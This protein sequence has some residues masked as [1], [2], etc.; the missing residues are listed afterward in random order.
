MPHPQESPQRW[1]AGAK[2]LSPPPPFPGWPERQAEQP[3][4]VRVVQAGGELAE[5]L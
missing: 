1:R 2:P 3:T 5:G 4:L